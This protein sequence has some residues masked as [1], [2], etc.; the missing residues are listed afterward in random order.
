ME[1]TNLSREKN[2]QLSCQFMVWLYSLLG[3]PS[4][5]DRYNEAVVRIFDLVTY[6]SSKVKDIKPPPIC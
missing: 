2:S 5:S 3:A 4:R 1:E 6:I